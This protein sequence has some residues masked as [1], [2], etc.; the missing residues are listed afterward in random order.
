[1]KVTVISYIRPSSTGTTTV[2]L[3]AATKTTTTTGQPDRGQT[4][5]GTAG[6]GAGGG[7]D[8]G[9]GAGGGESVLVRLISTVQWGYVAQS[10]FS[11]ITRL[12]IAITVYP[13]SAV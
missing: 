1:M 2:T 8:G 3:G 13:S 12:R 4:T 5:G 9:K 11:S 6:G 10:S 7:C